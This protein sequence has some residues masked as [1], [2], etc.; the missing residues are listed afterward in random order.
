MCGVL[1]SQ[2]SRLR[3]FSRDIVEDPRCIRYCRTIAFPEFIN[4]I[5][6]YEHSTEEMYVK[7]RVRNLLPLGQVPLQAMHL[8]AQKTPASVK[9]L[10][11]ANA[12]RSV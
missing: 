8:H 9:L 2:P 4:G 11:F 12:L 7:L 5:L 6:I 1:S 10:E 3:I